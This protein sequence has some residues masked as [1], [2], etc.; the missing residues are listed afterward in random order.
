MP[1]GGPAPVR[2]RAGLRGDEQ[3]IRARSTILVMDGNTRRQNSRLVL[4]GGRMSERRV[5]ALGNIDTKVPER[6][7]CSIRLRTTILTTFFT[8]PGVLSSVT[9]AVVSENFPVINRIHFRLLYFGEY[10]L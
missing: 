5:R 10:F 3:D 4:G 2:Y 1:E 9:T 8:F 7:I 6:Y